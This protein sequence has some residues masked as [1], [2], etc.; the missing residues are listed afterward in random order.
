MYICGLHSPR[1]H[2]EGKVDVKKWCLV[3]ILGCRVYE[4]SAIWISQLLYSSQVISPS[5][6]RDKRDGN[7]SDPGSIQTQSVFMKWSLAY[8]TKTYCDM[9]MHNSINE[10]SMN[11]IS[12]STPMWDVV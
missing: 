10:P 3:K 5:I 8:E 2:A 4:Q 12:L 6:S 9:H 7:Q 1:S 11:R